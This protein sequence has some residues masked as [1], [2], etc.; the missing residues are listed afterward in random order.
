MA[1]Y[2]SVLQWYEFLSGQKV[3]IQKSEVVFSSNA[4]V[5]VREYLCFVRYAGGV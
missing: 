5:E 1:Q 2:L 4:S 3:N